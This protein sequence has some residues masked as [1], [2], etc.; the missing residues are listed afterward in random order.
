MGWLYRLW[1]WLPIPL[2]LRW[3]IMWL[4]NS[5]FMIGVAAVVL[6]ERDEVLLFKHT[7]RGDIPWGLPGGWLQKREDPVR[8]VEREIQEESGLDVRVMH[9]VWV[10]GGRSFSRVDIVFFGR[11]LGG[12][13]QPSPEVS[14]A[15]FFKPDQMPLVMEDTQRIVQMA[16]RGKILEDIQLGESKPG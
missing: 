13:F 5:K 10:K 3:P 14:E 16:L 4:G 6:N 1:G 2:R 7:Y 8:A 12:V 15:A 11:F 9:P